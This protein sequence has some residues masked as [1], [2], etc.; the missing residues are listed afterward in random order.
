MTKKLLWITETQQDFMTDDQNYK[1][2]IAVPNAASILTNLE[3]LTNYARENDAKI[4]YTGDLHTWQDAEISREPDF[5]NTFGMHC[6]R[7]TYGARF[8]SQT[9]PRDPY[10]VDFNDEKM[11]PTRLKEAREIVLYKN[12][13]DIFKGNPYANMVVSTFLKPEKVIHAGVA[14][15]VCVD[16]AIMGNVERTRKYGGQVYAVTDAMMGLPHLD[17]TP[18]ATQKVI[19]KWE[20]SGV[21]LITTKDVLEG[22][23]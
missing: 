15:N 10:V 8:I 19:Q 2:L 21:K 9:L 3:A 7:G 1:G 23:V 17:K 13:V 4:L 18:L 12:H 11:N 20:D 16:L 5:V 22:R 6:E 14:T